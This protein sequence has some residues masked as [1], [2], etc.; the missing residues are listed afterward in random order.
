MNL[1]ESIETKTLIKVY[2]K[3]GYRYLMQKFR[4]SIQ[5]T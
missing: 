2:F 1:P 4:D 3:K 5:S